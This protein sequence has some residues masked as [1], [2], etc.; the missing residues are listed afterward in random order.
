M[1]TLR[2]VGMALLAVV[3]CFNLASCS[4]DD[5]DDNSI[6]TLTE[7]VGS[8][9]EGSTDNGFNVEVTIET[10]T[11]VRVVVTGKGVNDDST[12]SFTYDEETGTAR[13]QYDGTD[14]VASIKGNS[15]TVNL[16]T[17]KANLR[18]TK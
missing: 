13:F 8:V 5:D 18:R 12:H 3:L 9:W 11:Q 2:Y 16:G 7:L 14:C 17:F 15:M 4:D 6:P 1:K 10:A